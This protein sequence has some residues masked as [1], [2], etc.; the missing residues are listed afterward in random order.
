MAASSAH[1][2]I[3][4]GHA[5]LATEAEL[6]GPGER[7][8]DEGDEEEEADKDEEPDEDEEGE[9]ASLPP[10]DPVKPEHRDPAPQ[11]RDPKSR[12]R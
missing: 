3:N 7:D 10:G 2:A 12:K 5:R 1:F 6:I 4:C 11:S 9:K 8:D